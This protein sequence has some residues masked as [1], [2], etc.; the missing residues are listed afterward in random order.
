[1]R[2]HVHDERGT[3]QISKGSLRLGEPGV[4]G[5]VDLVHA[6]LGDMV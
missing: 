6:K 4:V 3:S 2:E 5:V 1:M